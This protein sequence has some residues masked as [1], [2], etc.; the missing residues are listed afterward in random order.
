MVPKG[1][2]FSNYYLIRSLRLIM[3]QMTDKFVF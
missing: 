2:S 1:N 3:S